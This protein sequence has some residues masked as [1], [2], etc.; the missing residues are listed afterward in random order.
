V[1]FH[2][3]LWVSGLFWKGVFHFV[4]FTFPHLLILLAPSAQLT[5]T[6]GTAAKYKMSAQ[7]FPRLFWKC[8][9]RHT[10][11]TSAWTLAVILLGRRPCSRSS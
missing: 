10:S 5:S 8:R 1:D 11:H 7:L 2:A 3:L 9:V 6:R 4:V